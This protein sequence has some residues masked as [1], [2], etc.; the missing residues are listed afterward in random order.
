MI[1]WAYMLIT[2]GSILLLFGTGAALF[3][4]RRL[5]YRMVGYEALT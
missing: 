4:V 5:A 2:S 1:S 3:A